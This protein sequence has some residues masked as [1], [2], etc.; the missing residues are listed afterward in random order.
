[1]VSSVRDY[2]LSV[3]ETVDHFPLE[4]AV[5]LRAEVQRV[6]ERKNVLF[7]AGNGGGATVMD[8]FALGM[9]LN[10]LRE[11]GFGNRAISLNSGMML[12]AAANDFGYE[13]MFS[14]Q[15]ET[16]AKSGDLF[17]A[18]SASG[19][20]MNVATAIDKAHC[21]GLRTAAIVGKRGRVT[22]NANVVI[23]ID[24]ESAAITEDVAMM[25]LHWLYCSFMVKQ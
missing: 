24:C 14:V 5:Q 4:A 25:L 13:R 11:T 22:E 7:T 17:V 6:V 19:C 10:I 1:M 21:M 9:S 2:F 18:L 20:S 3:G 16:L 12:S 8:H 23:E 15:L